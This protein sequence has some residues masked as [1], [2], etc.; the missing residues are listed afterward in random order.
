MKK[1]T[2]NKIMTRYF[3]LLLLMVVGVG[4]M[5]GQTDT[6]Y[7]GVYYIKNNNNAK[8]YLCSSIVYYD[9]NHYSDSGYMPYLTTAQTLTIGEMEDAVWRIVKD[10]SS[11]YYY[12]VHA[13]DGK[14]LTLNDDPT[15]NKDKARL[16]LHLQ[17]AK[18]GDNSLFLITKSGTWYNISPKNDSD[19]SLNPAGDNYD[20]RAGTDNKTETVTG[21]SGSKNVGGLVGLWGNSDAKSKWQFEALTEITATV[22]L[23][24]PTKVY[25][26]DGTPHNPAVNVV[27]NEETLDSDEYKVGYGNNINVGTATA[28]IIGFQEDNKIVYGTTTYIINQRPLTITAEAKSKTY[29][30]ADPEL[31]YTPN[32]L[33]GT[34]AVTGV[35]TRDEGEDVGTYTINNALEAGNNYDVT[36]VPANLTITPK[37]VGVEW[38]NTELTY[39]GSEQTPSATATGLVNSDEVMVTVTGAQIN[40]GTDYIATA[41]SLTG[42]KAQ[43]YLLPEG[44]TQS[45]TISPKSIADGTGV[46]TDIDIRMTQVGDKVEVTYVKDGEKTLAENEDYTVEIQEQGDDNHVI[47]TGIGNYCG[48]VQGLFVKS[49]FTKP[50]AATE[51]AAVY[52]A[53][54]DLASPEGITPYIVRKVNPSIGTIVIT[55]IDYIPKDVPVLMLRTGETTGFL[56]S[57]KEDETDEITAQ[58]KNSNQLKVAP[59]G[60]VDVEA[61]QTY[62]FYNGEF[63]LTK[64]GK[65]SEGRFYL[66]NPNYSATPPAEAE[67]QGGGNAP[68]LSVLRFVIEEEPT[69]INDVRSKTAEVKGDWFTLDGRKLN[70]KPTRQ[71]LY[72]LN[73]HKTI[74][75]NR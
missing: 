71:G 3:A 67:Q 30:D 28:I 58:T 59:E 61:A 62:M 44:L 65:L 31:T 64:K 43:N 34:D 21:I 15:G 39:S 66:Y 33:V 25:T 54:S 51:A 68:S 60:G 52:H 14:Y 24:D 32:G 37:K 74:I 13:F 73:G 50:T 49:V 36:Y 29:G 16:R 41:S 56:A 19:R 42:T 53:S 22:S 17:Y 35:L 38:T 75:R 70:G 57:P 10:E 23:A 8:Y 2:I 12:M 45:F 4:E 9:G 46:A 1:D 18:D 7:S 55:P 72:I 63:V 48:T 40:V 6:D 27:A 5:W 69:G 20:S 47:I 11:D 26:Y